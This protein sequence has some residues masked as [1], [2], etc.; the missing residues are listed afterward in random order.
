MS[1]DAEKTGLMKKI[2]YGSRNVAS[3]WKRDWQEQDQHW[4]FPSG[5]KQNNQKIQCGKTPFEKMHREQPTQEFVPIEEVLTRRLTSESKNRVNPRRQRG[6][7]IGKPNNSAECH[8]GNT[9]G[10]FRDQ[11]VR[12]LKHQ[13]GW[14]KEVVNSAIGVPWRT[15]DS[16][17]TVGRTDARVGSIP[18]PPLSFEGARIKEESTQRSFVRQL[19]GERQ[20][21]QVIGHGAVTKEQTMFTKLEWAGRK[22]TR[23]SSRAGVLMT[24]KHTLKAH[25]WV[26]DEIRSQ[27][28][29]ARSIR[30]E[31][32]AADFRKEQIS[33]TA[34]VKHYVRSRQMNMKNGVSRM[35]DKQQQCLLELSS[36]MGDHVQK[37]GSDD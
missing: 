33:R 8:I 34:I 13:D 18:I 28:I 6:V 16:K 14:D 26:Q 4:E 19:N 10:A 5:L 30:S 27:R 17:W 11:G 22:E 37:P 25:M 24:G 15:T 29:R 23:K 21:G 7:R 32:S 3:D 1:A 9:D 35:D 20:R 31:E 12:R 2:M 36:A